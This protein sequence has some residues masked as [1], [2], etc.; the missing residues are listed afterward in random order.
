MGTWQPQM[1]STVTAAVNLSY[2]FI[3][4]EDWMIANRRSTAVN[5]RLSLIDPGHGVRLANE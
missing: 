5:R 4:P 1:R 3:E 2:D